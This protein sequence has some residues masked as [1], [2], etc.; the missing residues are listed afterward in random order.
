MLQCKIARFR[1]ANLPLRPLLYAAGAAGTAAG[2]YYYIKKR[3]DGER[4]AEPVEKTVCADS[5]VVESD[6]MSDVDAVR[7]TQTDRAVAEDFGRERVTHVILE[8]QY[9]GSLKICLTKAEEKYELA[10]EYCV[11]LEKEKSELMSDGNALQSLVQELKKELSAMQMRH[12]EL[13]ME[14]KQKRLQLRVLQTKHDMMRTFLQKIYCK[15]TAAF[16]EG[17][18]PEAL[19]ML[20]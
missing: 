18:G 19:V 5:A 6:L 1:A 20:S 16:T 13:A 8:S 9:E 17:H 15:G 3:R 2:V 11:Q 12:D 14:C 7:V 10:L 4:T